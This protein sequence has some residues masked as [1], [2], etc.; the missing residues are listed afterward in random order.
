MDSKERFAGWRH[1][2]KILIQ[3]SSRENRR[4]VGMRRLFFDVLAAFLIHFDAFLHGYFGNGLPNQ[5]QG[6]IVQF[7]ET[8][9]WFYHVEFLSKD[10]VIKTRLFREPFEKNRWLSLHLAKIIS[11]PPY[12]PIYSVIFISFFQAQNAISAYI[13]KPYTQLGRSSVY[14]QGPM[15]QLGNRSS[16]TA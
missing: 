15:K 9:L 11:I 14:V 7:L 2:Q 3:R 5:V 8:H 13:A 6:Q 12:L 16:F 4:I 1:A 10:D